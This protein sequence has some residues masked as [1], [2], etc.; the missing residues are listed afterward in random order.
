MPIGLEVAMNL[1]TILLLLVSTMMS[2]CGSMNFGET[3][4]YTLGV[5]MEANEI[6]Q[7]YDNGGSRDLCEG[8]W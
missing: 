8:V 4:L 6:K 3:S 7:C 5:F 1:K 2:A